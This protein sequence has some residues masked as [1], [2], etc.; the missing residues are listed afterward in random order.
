MSG[1]KKRDRD[2]EW[3]SAY[4][5]L[6]NP[7][8]QKAKQSSNLVFIV[9]VSAIG[10][11]AIFYVQFM[12]QN[13]KLV[14][15]IREHEE[16][17]TNPVNADKKEWN[18][19]LQQRSDSLVN[20]REG[21]EKYLDQLKYAYRISREDFAYY[22]TALLEST[23]SD[24]FITSFTTDYNSVAIRGIVKGEDM[25]RQFAEFL[26]NEKDENNNAKFSSVKYTGFSRAA[27]AGD[28]FYEF[29]IDVT[30]WD[31]LN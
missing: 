7:G 12:N 2:L 27:A 23:G 5:D 18:L 1:I 13:A 6:E 26:T 8:R 14:R 20:Y 16:Y 10:I 25:P 17:M 3:L 30:L 4:R 28:D 19:T 29:T 22:E 11:A 9:G 24:S 21:A 31:K 15:E